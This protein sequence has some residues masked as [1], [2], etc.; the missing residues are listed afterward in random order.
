[1]LKYRT[2]M[3]ADWSSHTRK[4]IFSRRA[5]APWVT[6]QQPARVCVFPGMR[7]KKPEYCNHCTGFT[8]SYQGLRD[9]RNSHNIQV[10]SHKPSF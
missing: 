8:I 7:F 9:G 10:T 1:M 2:A 3:Q 5:E 6:Q 4:T